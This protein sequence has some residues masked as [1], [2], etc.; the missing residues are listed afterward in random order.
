M[1]TEPNKVIYSMVGVSKSYGKNA[2]TGQ[3]A[4][5]LDILSPEKL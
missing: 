5:R 3:A 4:T 1:S 2:A